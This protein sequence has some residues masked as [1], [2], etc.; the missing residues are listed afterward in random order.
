MIIESSEDEEVT[1]MVKCVKVFMMF[2]YAARSNLNIR[3]AYFMQKHKIEHRIKNIR[4]LISISMEFFTGIQNLA[5]GYVYISKV[6]TSE[7]FEALIYGFFIVEIP[8]Y[9]LQMTVQLT[10]PF[11]NSLERI[12]AVIYFKD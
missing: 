1:P 4:M 10:L 6:G 11:T 3:S 8:K 9:I 7:V 12:E 5:I 2:L